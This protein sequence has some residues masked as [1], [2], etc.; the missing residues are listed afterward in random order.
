MKNKK[1]HIGHSVILKLSVV[2]AI[3]AVCVILLVYIFSNLLL[4]EQA[5]I[6]TKQFVHLVLMFLV[7]LMFFIGFIFIHHILNPVKK[8]IVAVNEIRKGNLDYKI[9]F[10]GKDEFGHLAE[11]FNAMSAE[12][13]KMIQ[14]RDQLLLDVSHE[15]R[16]PITRSKLALEM[17]DDSKGKTSV[18]EDLKEMELMITDI[19][20]TAR[21]KNGQISLNAKVVSIKEL[22]L[23][24]LSSFENQKSRIIVNPVSENLIIKADE[25]KLIIAL[26]NI[27]EN[28]LKF[29]SPEGREIEISVFDHPDK[30]NLQVEDFGQGIPEDKIP[31][32]FEPFY[33]VDDSRS[34][35]S[36]G[37]GLGLHLCKRIMEAHRAE[38]TIK[39]KNDKSGIIVC[40]SFA[41]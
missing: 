37:Y 39:N 31:F 38:I 16:T 36:G 28:A 3:L 33:R 10:K 8:L 17:M 1:I 40:L 5:D 13:K 29:S 32:V 12:L 35:K 20:E 14:A 11:A 27:I 15:L 26:R 41:K 7:A 19:L 9:S 25:G 18:I 6:H 24:T 30:I 21:L 34:K 2:I 23:K 22:F 4:P